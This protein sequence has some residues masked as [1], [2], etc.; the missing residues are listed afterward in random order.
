MGEEIELLKAKLR[1]ARDRAEKAEQKATN[2]LIVTRDT[3]TKYGDLK[4]AE[5]EGYQNQ[6]AALQA[7]LAVYEEMRFRLLLLFFRNLFKSRKKKESTI[8]TTERSAEPGAGS[9]AEETVG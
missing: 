6:I 1:A 9:A 4:R 2:I 7:N 3:C 8:E 5:I